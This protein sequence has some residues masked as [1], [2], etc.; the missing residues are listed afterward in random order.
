MRIVPVPCLSDNYAYLVICEGTGEAAVVDPS[1]SAPVLAAV[2]REGVRLKAIWCTHH[3]HDHVGGNLELLA[4]DPSLPV[5]GHASD[6]GRIPGQTLF[7]EDGDEIAVGD[8]LRA[9]IIHNPGHTRGAITYYLADA[10]AA[11]TGDT[12]F[13]A[14]C[15]RMFEGTPPVMQASLATL[16]SILPDAARIYC[17]HEYTAANLRFAAAVEPD[18]AAVT[19]RAEWVAQLRGQNQPTMGAPL[20]DELATNPFLRVD[21]PAVIAAAR[22]HGAGSDGPAD[23][24]GALRAWKDA[25]K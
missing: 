10:P 2:D 15:G 21:Q 9:R 16:A 3:H 6:R 5:V 24:F 7:V 12:L 25:F 14:G 19:S 8:Q 4:A 1:E 18:S 23:V 20:S 13:L 22:A 11:F 17:G